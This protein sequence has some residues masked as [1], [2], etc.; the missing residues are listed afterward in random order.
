MQNK[1]PG[2]RRP[3][4]ANHIEWMDA[5]AGETRDY[6]DG[7][8]PRWS[9]KYEYEAF[10]RRLNVFLRPLAEVIPPGS[11]VL[12]FGCGSGELA[13]ALSDSGYRVIGL[14]S[15]AAMHSCSSKALQGRDAVMLRVDSGSW[16]PIELPDG[17]CDAIVS[18]SVLEYIANIEAQLSEFR[19]VVKPGGVIIV[20]VPNADSGVRKIERLLQVV[21]RALHLGRVINLLPHRIASYLNYILLS[22]NRW[23]LSEWQ[24]L[25]ASAG[26]ELTETAFHDKPLARISARRT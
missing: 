20:T 19:R 7:M 25:L 10:R 17:A 4:V 5:H 3:V 15:S 12:D 14:E 9:E 2:D 22:I 1:G 6:F 21:L 24:R 13:L 8:A 18:S 23:N 11:R 16:S 26:F